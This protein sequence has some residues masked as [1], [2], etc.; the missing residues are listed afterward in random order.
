MINQ[1]DIMVDRPFLLIVE[2][3]SKLAEIETLLIQ[4]VHQLMFRYNYNYYRSNKVEKDWREV[5]DD[6]KA[7]AVFYF[8]EFESKRRQKK[9][10]EKRRYDEWPKK[11]TDFESKSIYN[12]AV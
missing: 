10:Y 11:E 4:R 5:S 12:F 8:V 3:N 6:D 7:R 1:Y 9:N 2:A